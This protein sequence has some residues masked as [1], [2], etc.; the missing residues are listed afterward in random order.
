MQMLLKATFGHFSRLGAF[1]IIKALKN[2][3]SIKKRLTKA[4]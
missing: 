3:V 1:W 4:L 2:R